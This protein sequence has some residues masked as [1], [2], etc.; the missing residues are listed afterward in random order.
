[1]KDLRNTYSKKFYKV[2]NISDSY[3]SEYFILL[4]MSYEQSYTYLK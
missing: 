2:W 3:F 4:N 1:M